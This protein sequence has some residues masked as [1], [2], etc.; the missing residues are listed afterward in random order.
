MF[1]FSFNSGTLGTFLWSL[2]EDFSVGSLSAPKKFIDRSTFGCKHSVF[3]AG[4][5]LNCSLE[6]VGG[7][8]VGFGRAVMGHCV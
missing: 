5:V 3:C 1:E 7:E 4:E 2:S 6:V 8:A